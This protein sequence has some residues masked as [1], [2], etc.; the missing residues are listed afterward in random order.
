MATAKPPHWA[1]KLP[2]GKRAG[3]ATEQ[4]VAAQFKM[5]LNRSDIC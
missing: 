1:S 2:A 3:V 4:A 5:S